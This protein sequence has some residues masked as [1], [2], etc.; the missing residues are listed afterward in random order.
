[1]FFSKHQNNKKLR[2]AIITETYPP[3]INGVSNTLFELVKQLQK[4]HEVLILRPEEP[5]YDMKIDYNLKE[6][7]FPY[8]KIPF[9]NE[10]KLGIPIIQRISDSF[11]TFQPDIV[12]II[13]EGPLGF[14][15]LW[16]AKQMNLPVVADYRTNFNDYLKFYHIQ[17]L[18]EFI[19]I[20]LNYFHNQCDLNL[21][22]TLE[23]KKQLLKKQYKRIK[24]LGRGI[25]TQ[26][27][28]PNKYSSNIR[29]RFNIELN[30]IMFLYVGRIAPEK[31]LYF[32][33]NVIKKLQEKYNHIKFVFVGDGP[34]KSELENHYPEIIF[35]GKLQGEELSC[36]YASSDVFL[37]PSKTETFGNVFLESY[38]SGLPIIS[39]N[40][41]AAKKIYTN[42]QT[43][44]LMPLNILNEE[45]L[46]LKYIENYIKNPELIKKHKH[47][48]LNEHKF[49]LHKLSWE[50][51]S[52]QL[53]RYYRNLINDKSKLFFKA[54]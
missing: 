30:E 41:G 2:I 48:I 45:E 18:D 54:S 23:V 47:N 6:I 42:H 12:H 52:N 16:I 28:N 9:Y 51:I 34:I 53:I 24:V 33:C 46:W 39:Y 10:V 29:K 26:R 36:I 37:F 11:K 8:I 15:S 20:Y 17:Y 3:D 31:N 25:D 32:L 22:P 43:G 14:F 13:T 40:Y 4:N 7:F 49:K 21:V 35:T 1:M 5:Y 27:F 19:K 38:A 44:F 50:G